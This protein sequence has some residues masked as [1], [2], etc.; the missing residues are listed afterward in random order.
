MPS[1]I[2][3]F[4]V[5]ATSLI[6]LPCVRLPYVLLIAASSPSSSVGPYFLLAVKSTSSTAPYRSIVPPFVLASPPFNLSCIHLDA[7]TSSRPSSSM[8]ASTW[9]GS[10]FSN[11]SPSVPPTD[12]SP[13][14]ALEG[15]TFKALM[16][17]PLVHIIIISSRHVKLCEYPH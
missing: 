17:A 4:F 12:A 13:T 2:I 10:Y 1:F 16:V 11:L 8:G 9:P 7:P 5:V 15:P 14:S 6:V 3:L